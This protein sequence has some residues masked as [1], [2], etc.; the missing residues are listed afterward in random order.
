MYKSRKYG[1]AELSTSAMADIA[2]LLLV[3]FMVTTNINEEKG[4]S[5]LLP[6]LNNIIPPA[7]IHERNLFTIQINSADQLMVEGT[8]RADLKGLRNEVRDFILNYH[9]NPAL[10]DSPSDAIVSLKTDRGTSHKAFIHAL[11]EVQAAYYEIYAGQA[12][13]SV[14]EFRKLDPTDEMQRKLY[15]MSRK[16]IPM[17]ISIAEPT[18]IQ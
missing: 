18:S 10:S 15:E 14:E 8:Q 6:A 3:F 9:R 12:G 4:L 1:S 11:D 5:I 17:N 13:I 7:P 2:F 16:G